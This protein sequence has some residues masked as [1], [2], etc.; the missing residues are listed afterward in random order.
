MIIFA[1]FLAFTHAIPATPPPWADHPFAGRLRVIVSDDVRAEDR[2]QNAW[3][4]PRGGFADACSWKLPDDGCAMILP[5]LSREPSIAEADWYV[6]TIRQET[7]ECNGWMPP[8]GGVQ[9]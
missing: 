9:W 7:A 6:A 2:C 4:V 3:D 5:R 8:Y 1:A